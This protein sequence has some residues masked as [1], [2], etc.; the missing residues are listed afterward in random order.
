MPYMKYNDRNSALSVVWTMLLAVLA[1]PFSAGCADPRPD[2]DIVLEAETTVKA[3]NGYGQA[4]LEM[5][6]SGFM[7]LG[8]EF[9]DVLDVE[10]GTG[11]YPNVPFYSGFYVSRGEPMVSVSQ[12]TGDLFMTRNYTGVSFT[13]AQELEVGDAVTIVMARKGGCRVVEETMSLSYVDDRSKFASDSVFANARCVSTTGIKQGVLFRSASPVDNKRGRA[14][15]ASEI[16]RENGINCVLNLSSDSASLSNDLP[17][18]A[19]KLVDEDKVIFARM[20]VDFEN[21]AN[22]QILVDGLTRM[23]HCDGP[24]L[25]HCL[26]GK[27]RTGFVCM[28]LEMLCGATTEEMCQDYML[29]Y[30]NYYGITKENAPEKYD[31]ILEMNLTPMFD[32]VGTDAAEYLESFGMKDSDITLLRSKLTE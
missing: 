11:S 30:S 31:C 24:Y 22:I 27:D 23:A 19:A 2:G 1:I 20:G 21:L 25:I 10:A 14:A 17:E 32:L 15:Y 4:V 28:L 6:A 29:T 9:G 13:M 7:A 3:I 18:Y 12:E 8:F 16:A 5:P 26:E